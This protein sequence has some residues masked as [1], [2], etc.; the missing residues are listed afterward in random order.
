[1][2]DY[3]S[4]LNRWQSAGVLDADAAARIRSWESAQNRFDSCAHSRAESRS[5][6]SGIAWQGRV[7]LI[8]GGILLASG[9]VLFVS[10]H[11][12]QL[13]PGMRLPPRDGHG[14]RLP[15]WRRH[16]ARQISGN[17]DRAARRRHHLHRRRHRPRR[18]DLQ[19]PGALARGGSSCGRSQP[20]AAG[21]CS[22]TR[23]SRHFHCS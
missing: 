3:E 7:A 5:Q 12:D 17:L 8:L 13:G 11:W 19:H 9:V 6:A 18:P 23:P 2:P 22:A 4:F 1:M 16:H 21:C 14:H 10:A 15:S 20:S